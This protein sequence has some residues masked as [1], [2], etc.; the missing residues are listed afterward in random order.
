MPSN[1][2]TRISCLGNEV[3]SGVMRVG[4]R[5]AGGRPLSQKRGL[6]LHCTRPVLPWRAEHARTMDGTLP[7]AFVAAETNAAGRVLRAGRLRPRLARLRSLRYAP[8]R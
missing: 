6:F 3:F 1:S 7:A 8:R 5:C 4:F 2:T